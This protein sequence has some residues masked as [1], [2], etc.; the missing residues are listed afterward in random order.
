MGMVSGFMGRD[1][2]SFL[3][4]PRNLGGCSSGNRSFF[5]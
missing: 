3:H 5:T 1:L 2:V 4:G